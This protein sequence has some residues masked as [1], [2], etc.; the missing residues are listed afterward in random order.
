M[1]QPRCLA[2][3]GSLGNASRF[4]AVMYVSLSGSQFL[5]APANRTPAED[6]LCACL[7]ALRRVDVP[8]P[9]L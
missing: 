5:A 3:G 9:L 7:H 1:M 4:D 8:S 6:A 2:E